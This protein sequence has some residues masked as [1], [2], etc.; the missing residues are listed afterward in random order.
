MNY[1]QLMDFIAA[2][3]ME[4]QIEIKEMVERMVAEWDPNFDKL[5]PAEAKELEKIMQEKDYVPESE[6]NWD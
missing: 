2:L 1:E 5:T 6:I 4:K 3:P